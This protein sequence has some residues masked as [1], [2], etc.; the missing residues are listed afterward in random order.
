MPQIPLAQRCHCRKPQ[1]LML[2]EED[3]T[4]LQKSSRNQE[5]IGEKTRKNCLFIRFGVF[6]FST[7]AAFNTIKTFF[8]LPKPYKL[9]DLQ[10]FSNSRRTNNSISEP[11]Q[12]PINQLH[13]PSIQITKSWST[14]IFLNY[15]VALYIYLSLCSYYNTYTYREDVRS[16][17]NGKFNSNFRSHNKLSFVGYT[18]FVGVTW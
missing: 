14:E 15:T 2:N 16:F 13:K 18:F 17:C 10:Q 8:F 3:E 6:K 11:Y 1:Q 12:Q 5:K 4:Q 7:W 9:Q